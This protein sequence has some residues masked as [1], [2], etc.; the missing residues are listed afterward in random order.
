M[1][2]GLE[3]THICKPESEQVVTT[4]RAQGLKLAMLTGDNKATARRLAEHLQFDNELVFAEVNPSEKR[5]IVEGFQ[6]QGEQ[7]LFIG[8]GVND[9][10]VLAQ[11]EVGVSIN[12]SSDITAEAAGI[13]LLNDNLFD[14]M[15]ALKICGAAFRRIKY[16][17]CWAFIYNVTLIPLA[18]G[19]FYPL[20]A[21]IR[22]MFAGI[23][24]ALSDVS[25]IISSIMMRLLY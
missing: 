24:M 15:E 12:S 20:G 17:F 13:V 21:R 11:A 16:N 18:M 10:P 25:I 5:L 9:E 7:V 1:L 8:D 3:E 19:A 23:A 2:I 4:L 14:L 6:E 22:P